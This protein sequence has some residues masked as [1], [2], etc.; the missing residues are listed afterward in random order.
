M[1]YSEMAIKYY[2]EHY[3]WTRGW[4]DDHPYWYQHGVLAQNQTELDKMHQE[5]VHWL[6]KNIDNPERH[7]RWTRQVLAISV[8]FRHEKDYLWFKLRF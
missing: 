4:D 3:D 5:I 8:K 6:Y 1:V 2:P 7:C